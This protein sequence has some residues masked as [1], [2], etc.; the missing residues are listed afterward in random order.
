MR[1]LTHTHATILAIVCALAFIGIALTATPQYADSQTAAPITGWLWSDNIGWVSM[2]CSNTSSCGTVNYSVSIAADGTLSGYAW[3]D[4]I[5][6][7]KFGGLSSFPTGSGTVAQNAA[8]SGT[9][10]RGWARACAGTSTGDCASMTS[11]TDGWDGWIALSGT[12]FG[13]TLSG[14]SF[15]GYSWGDENVGWLSWNSAYHVAQ[16]VYLPCAATQGYQCVGG[17]S[18]H[19]AA[20]CSVTT[21]VCLS[22]GAGWFCA[23]DNHLCT[24]PA[25]PTGG[26]SGSLQAKPSLVKSGQTT[27]IIWSITNATSCTVTGNGN[28]WSVVASPVA[29]YTSNPITQKTTYTLHCTGDGGTLDQTEEITLIPEWQER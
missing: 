2:N 5:G 11:R 26:A 8:M 10:L 15:S 28:S 21:D 7:I 23:S 14:G 4:N 3:S 20:D 29:G 19:L 18:E 16:T 1:A 13:P 24:A 17:N 6:W 22:H 9:S 12:N 27:K 25:P